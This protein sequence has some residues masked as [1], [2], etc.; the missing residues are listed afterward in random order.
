[1]VTLG[2]KEEER[3]SVVSLRPGGQSPSVDSDDLSR[4]GE[5]LGRN[6]SAGVIDDSDTRDP[7]DAEVGAGSPLRRHAL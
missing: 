6:A 2:G 1:M 3:F 7:D 4:E 5:E